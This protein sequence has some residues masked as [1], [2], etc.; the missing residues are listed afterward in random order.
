ML[1]TRYRV[2]EITHSLKQSYDDSISTVCHVEI[3]VEPVLDAAG[4]S[5]LRQPGE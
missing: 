4:Y 1:L 3:L 5:P 2:I